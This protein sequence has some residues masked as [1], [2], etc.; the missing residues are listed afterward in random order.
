M[1]FLEEDI[2]ETADNYQIIFFKEGCS[3]SKL[4]K[5]IKDA[6]PCT[7]PKYELDPG[8]FTFVKD[9]KTGRVW[10]PCFCDCEDSSAEWFK[11]AMN[12]I[13]S[14]ENLRNIAIDFRDLPCKQY[15]QTLYYDILT[16]IIK[17]NGPDIVFNILNYEFDESSNAA[18]TDTDTDNDTTEEYSSDSEET[19]SFN[20]LPVLDIDSESE[21]ESEDEGYGYESQENE[22]TPALNTEDNTDYLKWIYRKLKATQLIDEKMLYSEYTALR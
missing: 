5:R 14:T 20:E 10:C 22:S 1:N 9:E 17:V 3:C 12:K 21:C 19:E 7:L 16:T 11:D 13:V 6:H 4:S 18:D 2:L 15:S 8:K